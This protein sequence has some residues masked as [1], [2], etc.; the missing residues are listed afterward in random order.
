MHHRSTA[1]FGS[2]S[3]FSVVNNGRCD[4]SRGQGQGVE[5]ETRTKQSPHGRIADDG[6]VRVKTECRPGVIRLD[7][8]SIRGSKFPKKKK[9]KKMFKG[10]EGSSGYPAPVWS[11][12]SNG[13]S[14]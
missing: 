7:I 8:G 3:Y 14:G 13:Y 5:V 6:S 11:V 1:L 12:I 4:V 2:I 10:H 9:K